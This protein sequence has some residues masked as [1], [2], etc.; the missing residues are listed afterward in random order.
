MNVR[1]ILDCTIAD[2]ADPPELVEALAEFLSSDANIIFPT[3]LSVND[4]QIR[5]EEE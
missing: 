2:Q 1:I 3:I 4:Y 5:M